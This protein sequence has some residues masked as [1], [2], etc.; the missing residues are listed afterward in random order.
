MTLT[1]ALKHLE[2][3]SNQKMDAQYLSK[4]NGAGDNQFDVRIG[5]IRKVAKRI[6]TKHELALSLWNTNNTEGGLLATLIIHPKKLSSEER[7]KCYDWYHLQVANW[8]NAYIVKNQPENEKLRKQWMVADNPMAAYAGWNL[9]YQRIA[10]NADPL[11]LSALLDRIESE[12]AD[13][14]P[15]AQ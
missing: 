8:L 6:K 7:I 5:D 9:T 11:D 4:R 12:T 1:E 10:K 14:A 2:V 3:L 15:V 13:A